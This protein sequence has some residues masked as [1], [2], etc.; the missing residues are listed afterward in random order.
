MR[1][2]NVAAFGKTRVILVDDRDQQLSRSAQMGREIRNGLTSTG[3]D[4][5]TPRNKWCAP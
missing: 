4:T 3:D 5:E 2:V 1:T